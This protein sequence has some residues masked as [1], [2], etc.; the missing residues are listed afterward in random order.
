MILL[1]PKQGRR[2]LLANPR[3][4]D[5]LPRHS[6]PMPQKSK[7]PA[8]HETYGAL[9]IL[10]AMGSRQLEVLASLPRLR[11]YARIPLLDNAQK[12]ARHLGAQGLWDF[13]K[14]LAVLLRKHL[15]PYCACEC[16]VILNGDTVWVLL[17]YAMCATPYSG[18]TRKKRHT[19]CG[20]DQIQIRSMRTSNHCV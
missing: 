10:V 9:V 14:L 17:N 19:Q 1:Q 6:N 2:T 18:A 15:R 7:G 13:P 5:W 20:H 12:D 8:G 4:G 16:G 11:R 3:K